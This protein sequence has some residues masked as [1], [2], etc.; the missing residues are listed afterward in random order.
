MQGDIDLTVAEGIGEPATLCATEVLIE[1]MARTPAVAEFTGTPA[2]RQTETVG[3]P[4]ITCY[5]GSAPAA[6]RVRG[7]RRPARRLGCRSCQPPA[8]SGMVGRAVVAI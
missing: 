8:V 2:C 4:R 3:R 6:K 1:G 5:D 7:A